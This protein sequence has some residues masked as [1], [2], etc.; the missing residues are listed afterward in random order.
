MSKL[1]HELHQFV[2]QLPRY[3]FSFDAKSIPQNGIYIL[4]ENGEQGHEADRIVRIGAHTGKN[5]LRSRLMQHFTKENKDRSIFRKNIGRCLLHREND[6]Y[7]NVWELD[8]TSSEGKRA[9]HHLV[10]PE[11]QNKIEKRVSGYMQSQ[12]SF[13]VL[14]VLDKDERLYLESRIIS[15]VSLCEECKPSTGWL[16]LSSPKDKI[17]ESGLWQVNELYKS[18]LT[19]ED[20]RGLVGLSR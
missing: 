17:R 15:T 4:F 11:Y 8:S 20:F 9:Y 19:G 18:P 1:C 7:L 2:Y 5:Q 6:P 10:M 3:N 12:F 14:E 16:G 13:A